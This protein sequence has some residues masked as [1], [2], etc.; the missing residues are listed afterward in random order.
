MENPCSTPTDIESRIP[1]GLMKSLT[2]L[3]SQEATILKQLNS[4]PA[5]AQ[6]F[7]TNPGA[8]LAQM[9]I[10][11]DPDLSA[12]LKAAAG[13]ANPFVPKTYKLPDGTSV[14]PSIKVTFA[15]HQTTKSD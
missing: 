7:V 11:V 9:G 1:P 4:N 13:K 3:L 10:A 5:L 8:A 2:A 14:T 12:A 6:T 15:G